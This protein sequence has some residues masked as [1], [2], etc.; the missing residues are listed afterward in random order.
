MQFFLDFD[1][2]LVVG[3]VTWAIRNVFPQM[4]HDYDLPYS[5]ALLETALLEGQRQ[6]SAGADDSAL[7]DNLFGRLGWPDDLKGYLFNAVFDHY[8]PS[9]FDD[10]LPF[11]HRLAE[12]DLPVYVLSN[13]NYAPDIAQ[14]LDIAPHITEFFTPKL[15][16]VPRGKPHRDLWD[17]ICA[18]YPVKG[19]ILV[20][21]DPWSDGAFAEACGLLCYIVD[22]MDR[23]GTIPMVHARVGTL[24]EVLV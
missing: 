16:H 2:T 15:C 14:R 18:D 1:D 12:H 24:D 19:A 10:T 13:N 3:P 11:L 5:P 17:S 4:I 8:Q 23:F 7:L 21:D 20:G 9:L 22:R 6:A